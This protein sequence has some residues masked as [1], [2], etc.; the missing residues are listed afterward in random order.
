[1]HIVIFGIGY[2]GLTAA[3]CIASE[4]HRVTGI[5]VSQDKVA[6]LLAGRAPIIEPGIDAMMA[7][8]LAAGRLHAATDIG[9][10]LD[11]ADIAIVCVGTPSAPD[12]SHNMRYIADV[13]RQIAEAVARAPR[14]RILTV[15]YRST[16]R[17]GTIEELVIPLFESETGADWASKVEIVYNPEFLRE[18]S[19]VE[20]YFAP[21]KIVIGTRDGQ[22][23]ANMEA[24]HANIEAPT[25]HVAF[26]TAEFTK[27]ADNSW[28]AVK[29]AYAN[30]LGRVCLDLG[31]PPAEMH[32]IFVSDT[33][34]NISACYMRPG[35]AFGGSCLPKDV[36][37]LQHIAG[38]IGTTTPLVD[39]LL[40]SN[41]A[42]KHRLFLHAT[43]GL[44]PGARVLM[45]GLAFKADT[46]D[47]RES[48]N[49]DLARKLLTAGYRL[50]IF[51]P[52]V[53]ARK[54]IGANLGYAYSQLPQLSRLLVGRDTAEAGGYD[55]VIATNRT[56]RLLSLPRGTQ[57][58]DLG[59]LDAVREAE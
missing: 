16:F 13:T 41:E 55:R 40:R 31:V 46:D 34:L 33:K 57:I 8:A 14:D 24:L 27:F 53:D 23:S 4:G 11:G 51:D 56:V 38:D 29:V 7:E 45:A 52:A 12:G 35:G 21:P 18:G 22:P 43:A 17:P 39:S 30:E 44:A 5:D 59:R 37:A 6:S 15:A 58:V 47:L 10:H 49:V 36:R 28:H 3:C 48:P 42:H 50:D 1:M 54:L 25:F 26:R 9:D 2:V 32:R 20:D 19:A